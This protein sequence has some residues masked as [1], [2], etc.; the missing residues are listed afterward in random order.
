METHWLQVDQSRGQGRA[1][2]TRREHGGGDNGQRTVYAGL[3]GQI[4]RRE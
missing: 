4:L 2:R 3:D 1:E